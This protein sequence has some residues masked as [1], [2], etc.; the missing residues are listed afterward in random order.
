MKLTNFRIT[1]ALLSHPDGLL[2][3]CDAETIAEWL[4]RGGERNRF[5]AKQYAELAF[6]PVETYADVA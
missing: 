4:S 2:A 1:E 3:W 5:N 6:G